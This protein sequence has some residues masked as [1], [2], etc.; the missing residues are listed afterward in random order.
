MLIIGPCVQ[1][2]LALMSIE[3]SGK[4][5]NRNIFLQSRTFLWRIFVCIYICYPLGSSQNLTVKVKEF[6][7]II[8]LKWLLKC[9]RSIPIWP[10]GH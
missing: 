7:V 3:R 5:E 2:S 10:K 9:F 1:I 8:F 4:E 6:A